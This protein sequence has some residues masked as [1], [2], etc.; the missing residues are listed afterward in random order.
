MV[1]QGAKHTSQRLSQGSTVKF[2][3]PAVPEGAEGAF[4]WLEGWQER[5]KEKGEGSL[6]LY[7]L[8]TQTK[9]QN[10]QALEAKA[11][12]VPEPPL[13]RPSRRQR[14]SLDR[15]GTCRQ[16]AYSEILD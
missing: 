10:H 3:W 12:Q 15:L 11:L 8:S 2:S 16:V 6:G 4:K 7:I 14:S 1:S 13:H 9:S 5:A